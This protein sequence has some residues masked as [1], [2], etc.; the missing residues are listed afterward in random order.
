MRIRGEPLS[1]LIRRRE[2][3]PLV[4]KLEMM[5]GLCSGL[6]HAHKTGMVHRDIKP[7]NLMVDNDGGPLKILDFGI[8][9]M[10]GSG[11]TSH[12]VLVGT[13]NYMSPEQITGRGTIDLRSD[14]F[15]VGAVLHEVF[16]Y[17]RAFPGEMTDVLYKI[18]HAQPESAAALSPG[19]DPGI[20]RAQA[21]TCHPVLGLALRAEDDDRHPRAAADLPQ[22]GLA[23]H[24][25]E[26]QIEDDERGRPGRA[27]REAGLALGGR[28]HDVTVAL[29]AG[30]AHL[31]DCGVI[32]DDEDPVAH[33]RSNPASGVR[34]THTRR[35]VDDCTDQRSKRCNGA[36]R[37]TWRRERVWVGSGP[38]DR[39]DRVAVVRCHA[40]PPAG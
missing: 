31:V 38:G 12:G 6:A 36:P 4:R 10:A 37:P 15:A 9:R 26:A 13:I 11:L 30:A 8:V 2:P 29:E 17:Q 24:V 1:K 19:L 16:T 5:E 7:A 40:G 33:A 23:G 3:I 32:V 25:R 34:G 20:V 22:H 39:A 28:G 27:E 21:K 18:V 35:S 14:V